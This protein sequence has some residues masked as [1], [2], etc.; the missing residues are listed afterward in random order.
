MV[1]WQSRRI[2]IWQPFC[3][4]LLLLVTI[5]TCSEALEDGA[6]K[7]NDDCLHNG[8]CDTSS[9]SHVYD[10]KCICTDSYTGPY[11]ET[12]KVASARDCLV[13]TDCQNG[14]TCNFLTTPSSAAID[15]EGICDCPSDHYGYHCQEKCPC[16]NDGT[17]K[18]VY[19]SGSFK[20]ECTDEFYGPL[21]TT[22]WDGERLGSDSGED[23]ANFMLVSIVGF[24]FGIFFCLVCIASSSRWTRSDDNQEKEG[25]E[26]MA[27]GSIVYR[28]GEGESAEVP[29]TPKTD[30]DIDDTE[31][32]NL[33]DLEL[34]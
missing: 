10:T 9:K 19:S 27:D 12:P 16:Q 31:P 17:C 6:C 23:D 22:R 34:T 4:L 28:N 29:G 20:C 3:S 18:T 5:S 14:G 26:R 30:P 33:P 11:C 1:T 7:S 13:E 32:V 15:T 21:C 25:V 8:F 24:S 2:P